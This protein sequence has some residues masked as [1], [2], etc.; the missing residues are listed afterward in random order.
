LKDYSQMLFDLAI[1][2]EGGKLDNPSR[3]SK[4]VG[5]ALASALSR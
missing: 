2:A 3:F 4:Q 5:D 1:V